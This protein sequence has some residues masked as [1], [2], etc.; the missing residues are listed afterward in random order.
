MTSTYTSLGVLQELN[1][2]PQL[3][4]ALGLPLSHISCMTRPCIMMEEGVDLVQDLL[5]ALVLVLGL[6]LAQAAGAMTTIMLT[7][8]ITS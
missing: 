3:L 4:K 7:K 6:T 2:R 5:R 1:P 8:M